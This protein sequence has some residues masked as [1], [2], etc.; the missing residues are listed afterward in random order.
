MDAEKIAVARAC[1]DASHDGSLSF[2]DIIGRLV[3]AG[4]EGYAVD[5]RRST[6][7]YY[8]PGGDS[9]RVRHAPIRWLGCQDLR[10]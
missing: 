5:Y 4:F 2:P 1:L 8:L 9:G 3:D 10:P 7:I 6:Q